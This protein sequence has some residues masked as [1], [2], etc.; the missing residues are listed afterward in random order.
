MLRNGRCDHFKS[1]SDL[2]R[3][4]PTRNIQPQ[5]QRRQAVGLQTR[6]DGD[7]PGWSGG[8]CGCTTPP[9]TQRCGKASCPCCSAACIHFCKVDR[10]IPRSRAMPSMVLP[11]CRA[12]SMACCL[13]AAEYVVRF[14]IAHLAVLILG[15]LNSVYAQLV[16]PQTSATGCW[17]AKAEWRGQEAPLNAGCEDIDD[18]SEVRRGMEAWAAAVW[19]RRRWR[20]AGVDASPETVGDKGG[21]TGW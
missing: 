8:V 16:Q 9:E 12:S 19:A 14:P 11:S 7:S 17:T 6:M 2:P 3:L 21:G 20:E 18:S 13:N 1:R 15:V 4:C 10:P 5:V